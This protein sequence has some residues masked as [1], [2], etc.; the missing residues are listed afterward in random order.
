MPFRWI[1]DEGQ[2]PEACI[3]RLEFGPW[4]EFVFNHPVPGKNG[5]RWYSLDDCESYYFKDSL[6]FLERLTRLFRD[7]E[8]LL[9]RYS[10]EQI[11]QGLW[12]FITA[13]ELP[14]VLEDKSLAFDTRQDCIRSVPSLYQRLLCRPGF[15]K[16]AFTYWDPLT[17]DFSDTFGRTT[18]PDLLQVQDS[19]FQ[20]LNDILHQ[21][22]KISFMSAVRGLGH[23][24]HELGQGAI[25]AALAHRNDL[26]IFEHAYGLSCIRGDVDANMPPAF[27]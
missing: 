26:T 1:L 19:M 16:I 18:S 2:G 10:V 11:K 23:L 12:C 8:I 4:I 14:D 7:P 20:S 6:L 5:D 24:H 13:F 15:E 27:N 3:D 17:Y 25:H 22:P 21:K 9:E